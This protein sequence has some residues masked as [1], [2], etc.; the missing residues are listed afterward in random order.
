MIEHNK[1]SKVKNL[2]SIKYNAIAMMY[3]SNLLDML[4]FPEEYVSGN[5]SIY[6]YLAITHMKAEE[7]NEIIARISNNFELYSIWFWSFIVENTKY[8]HPPANAV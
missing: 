3:I 7:L 5:K 6:K 2:Q 1:E 8:D 4:L